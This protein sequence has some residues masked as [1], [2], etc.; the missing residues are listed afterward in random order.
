MKTKN[1]LLVVVILSIIIVLP[2]T[3]Y[4]KESLSWYT[5]Y[6][7]N[8][9]NAFAPENQL[10]DNFR[11]S[12]LWSIKARE[13]KISTYGNYL[14]YTDYQNVTCADINTGKT[15]WTRNFKQLNRFFLNLSRD[16]AFFSVGDDGFYCL[17]I[18]NGQTLWKVEF[19]WS[20]SSL[21]IENKVVVIS[22]EGEK[23]TIW[24]LDINDGKKLFSLDFGVN[25]RHYITQYNNSIIFNVN[26]TI[27]RISLD[28]GA[29]LWSK[30]FFVGDNSSASA[31]IYQSIVVKD[32]KAV[33]LFP[34]LKEYHLALFDPE[35]GEIIWDIKTPYKVFIMNPVI[36]DKYV[37]Y[38]A[39]EN[40]YSSKVVAVNIEDGSEINKYLI[41]SV[42][43]GRLSPVL[44]ENRIIFSSDRNVHGLVYT[45]FKNSKLH[46]TFTALELTEMAFSSN[47]II[48]A[49]KEEIICFGSVAPV[50]YSTK[51]PTY[52]TRGGAFN[53]K[54]PLKMH[55]NRYYIC[56]EDFAPLGCMLKRNDY[57]KI[58]YLSSV[59][60]FG[61]VLGSLEIEIYKD[62]NTIKV[63]TII[64]S[65]LD[66]SI[67]KTLQYDK[68]DPTVKPL[69]I[70]NEIMVPLR[71]LAESLGCKVEWKADTKEI[72]VTY[73]P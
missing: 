26:G 16:K 53:L 11:L 13:A 59:V 18:S 71:F 24:C 73:Q 52:K 37:Y 62:L 64:E 22:K 5:Q 56:I 23:Y 3:V 43:Y 35:T 2:L 54:L 19:V 31:L 9:R 33:I 50:S 21:V 69:V 55:K 49:N 72:I 47:K 61:D 30:R 12:K 70:G 14:V 27:Y 46:S 65:T 15:I 29:V 32:D 8:N 17:D 7:N 34:N 48:V 66:K 58:Y 20:G 40:N 44:S 63:T 45:D 6:G 60:S 39:Y 25:P 36:T 4:Q 1:L 41:G 51:T 38:N 57:D 67:F 28:D 42:E 10:P 68:I